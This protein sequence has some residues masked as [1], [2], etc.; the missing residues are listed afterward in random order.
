VKI[1]GQVPYVHCPRHQWRTIFSASRKFVELGQRFIVPYQKTKSDACDAALKDTPK[2]VVAVVGPIE[3]AYI[4]GV[5]QVFHGT[6]PRC[7]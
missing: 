2:N 4:R 6:D 5:L 3:Q 7:G 1:E